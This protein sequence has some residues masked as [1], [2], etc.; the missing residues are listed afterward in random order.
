MIPLHPLTYFE[1]YQKKTYYQN[2]SRFNNVYSRDNSPKANDV[3][4]EITLHKYDDIE[5]YWGAIYIKHNNSL[6]GFWRNLQ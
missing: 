5:T 2:E 4:R 3:T 1:N 6:I